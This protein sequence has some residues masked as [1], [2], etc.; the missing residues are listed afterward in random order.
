MKKYI[1]LIRKICHSFAQTSGIEYEELFSEAVLCYYESSKS[2]DKSRGVKKSTWIY[3][4]ISNRL[5]SFIEK[6][7][8]YRIPVETDVSF[9]VNY[10]ADF[11]VQFS[12]LG[13]Q[14]S[15]IIYNNE[16][17]FHFDKPAKYNRGV[18]VSF[19]REE[20][21]WSWPVIWRA[22]SSI[23]TDLKTDLKN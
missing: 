6:E 21:K 1:N 4:I 23:K 15:E 20:M 13:K 22:M 7:K 19:L 14:L 18:L 11:G 8:R 5:I 10:I 3:R 9:D 17:V 2:F 16:E 12:E